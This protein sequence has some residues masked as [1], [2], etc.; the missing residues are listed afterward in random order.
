MT[1]GKRELLPGIALAVAAAASVTVILTGNA[2]AAAVV[3]LFAMPAGGLPGHGPPPADLFMESV[4]RRDGSLGWHQLCPGT[5]RQVSEESVRKVADAQR[6]AE[7]GEGLRL[8][9]QPVR[10]VARPHGGET[11]YYMVTAQRADGWAGRRLYIVQTGPGGC[12]E[13]VEN[14]DG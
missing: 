4:V 12:V 5:Q 8:K 14:T 10:S 2:T 11:R 9:A 3:G 1:Q 6:A 7:A 13:D